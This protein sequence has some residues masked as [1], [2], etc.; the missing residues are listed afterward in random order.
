MVGVQLQK[1]ANNHHGYNMMTE[2]KL[3]LATRFGNECHIVMDDMS[4]IRLKLRWEGSQF[5]VTLTPNTA[6]ITVQGPSGQTLH[7]AQHIQEV[8]GGTVY[9]AKEA[10]KEPCNPH[11]ATQAATDHGAVQAATDHGAA[12]ATAAHSGTEA[13]TDRSSS[14][15]EAATDHGAAEATAEHSATEAATDHSSSG[16]AKQPAT[17]H[18]AAEATTAHSATEATQ[19]ATVHGAAA[20]EPEFAGTAPSAAGG[21]VSASVTGNENIQVGTV[22]INEQPTQDIRAMSALIQGMTNLLRSSHGS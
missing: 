2:V 15:E 1:L 21:T 11:E 6:Y 16:E 22:V 19:P 18:G 3:R 12:E 14:G 8:V 4:S 9:A 17:D 10:G 20:P 7:L 13:A 5:T